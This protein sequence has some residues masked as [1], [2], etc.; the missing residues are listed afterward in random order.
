MNRLITGGPPGATRDV[1]RIPG[2]YYCAPA[3]SRLAS[4]ETRNFE[5]VRVS[6]GRARYG[7][8]HVVGGRPQGVHSRRRDKETKWWRSSLRR[9]FFDICEAVAKSEG[10]RLGPTVR[11]DLAIHVRDMPLHRPLAQEQ[12]RSYLLVAVAHGQVPQHL[13]LPP[14]QSRWITWRDLT[15]TGSLGGQSICTRQ[16]RGRPQ[17]RA[18]AAC[19]FERCQDVRVVPLGQSEL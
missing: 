6:V 16:G 7:G 13:R 8:N 19:L 18:D 11:P 14:R 9:R 1:R 15:V 12:L 5:E 10:H 17:I 3:A 4:G 2:V